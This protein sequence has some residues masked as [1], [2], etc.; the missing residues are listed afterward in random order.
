[1]MRKFIFLL[2]L[3]SCIS[4][5]DKG[6]LYFKERNIVGVEP[7]GDFLERMKTDKQLRTLVYGDLKSA[8]IIEC[9]LLRNQLY[10]AS[11]KSSDQEVLRLVKIIEPAYQDN[12][13]SFINACDQVLATQMGQE[14]LKIQHEYVTK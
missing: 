10:V 7:Y 8:R 2:F 3:S 1:M 4:I 14:F 6:R 12:N 13:E 11:I 5:K 9:T